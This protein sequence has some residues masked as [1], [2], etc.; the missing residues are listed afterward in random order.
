MPYIT[1]TEHSNIQKQLDDRSDLLEACKDL[2]KGLRLKMG[3]SAIQLRIEL[4]EQTI[5][6][7]EKK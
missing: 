4:A 2:T 7:T 1:E 3:K 5:A 6:K